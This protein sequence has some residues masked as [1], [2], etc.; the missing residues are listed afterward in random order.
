MNAPRSPLRNRLFLAFWGATLVSNIGTWI[1]KVAEQWLMTRLSPSPLMVALV[2]A[3]ATLPPLLLSL[4]AG[5]LADVVDR[6]RLLIAMQLW[7]AVAAGVLG[8]LTIAG[9]VTP[10]L[11]LTFTALLSVGD[12]LNGPAWA[13]L[14]PDIVSREELAVA[15][16]L[17]AVNFNLA[18][19]IGP[20]VGGVLIA[21]TGTGTAF[22]VNG[23]SFLGVI[24]VLLLWRSPV[25]DGKLPPEHL[26]SAIRSGLRYVRH[27]PVLAWL[28]V[29]TVAFMWCAS[30]LWALLP[31]LA[32]RTLGL[33][34]TGYGVLV[35]CLGTGAVL[36]AFGSAWLARRVS[37]DVVAD[38]ATVAFGTAMLGIGLAH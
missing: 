27:E 15:I 33:G 1:H 5:A 37:I 19:A 17:N 25:K 23:A 30:A 6:R 9:L 36:G 35:G 18:R 26:A 20:T 11:L 7:M 10:W 31:V 12:A 38:A 2:T 8:G 13:A 32:T 21:A 24:V 4:P 16:S 29:R 14:V 34:A 22:L 3:A 28:L